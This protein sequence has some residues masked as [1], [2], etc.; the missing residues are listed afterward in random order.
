[1]CLHLHAEARKVRELSAEKN[2]GEQDVTYSNL[3]IQT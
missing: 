2:A 1:M 3:S